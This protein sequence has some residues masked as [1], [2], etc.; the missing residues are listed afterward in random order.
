MLS[1]APKTVPSAE[2]EPQ[3]VYNCLPGLICENPL[4]NVK[5]KAPEPRR[6]AFNA[7]PSFS[8]SKYWSQLTST[9]AKGVTFD[10]GSVFQLIYLLKVS[11]SH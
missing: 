7:Y 9:A 4:P 10:A 11:S 6:A 8:G 2:N 1:W 5:K 3:H